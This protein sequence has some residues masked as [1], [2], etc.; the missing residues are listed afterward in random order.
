MEVGKLELA[1]VEKA[2]VG[3]TEVNVKELSEL[4]LAVIGGGLGDISLG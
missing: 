2:I 3:G 1:A 4:E